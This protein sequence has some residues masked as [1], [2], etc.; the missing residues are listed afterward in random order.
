MTASPSHPDLRFGLE[1]FW[2]DQ[3]G[4]LLGGWIHCTDVPIRFMTVVVGD[5]STIVCSFTERA[6]IA[7]HFPQA[8]AALM[9]GFEVYVPCRAG[10]PVLFELT[11]AEG[12][13]RQPIDLPRGTPAVRQPGRNPGWMFEY[14]LGEIDREGKTALE[15]GGRKA[16]PASRLMRDSFEKGGRCL[17]FDIHAA[18]GVDIVGDAHVLS[19]VVGRES[20]DAVMSSAVLEH[21]A[22][23]W[24]IAAEIN[25][26]LKP[27][28]LTYH[29]APQCW[30]VHELPNDFWR[31]S[32]E[33]LKVLFGPAFGFEVLG[34]MMDMPMRIYPD[35]RKDPNYNLPF[36]ET[37]G[38]AFILSR[39]VADVDEIARVNA[40]VLKARAQKYPFQ[41]FS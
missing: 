34:A 15:I 1:K 5:D 38:G 19:E 40:D 6:D 37:Y 29:W 23:P 9:S 27:G 18:P 39:K 11:T 7:A 14:L 12:T 22:M 10:V 30:P 31:Y 24:Q 4:L 17:G 8:S 33:G 13:I 16:H 3:H 2:C 36:F 35:E 20:L 25:R 32:D 26:A 41:D 28:G 21:V